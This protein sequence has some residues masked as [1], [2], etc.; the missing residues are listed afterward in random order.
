MATTNPITG[1]LIKTKGYSD[2]FDENFDK[3]D[4]SVRLEVPEIDYD[5]KLA[6]RKQMF[7]DHWG[8][9]GE[10]GE[11]QCQLKLEM[12]AKQ[13]DVPAIWEDIKPYQSQ[14]TGEIIEG[15]VA[16][17][18]HLK[19]HGLVEAADLP[20]EHTQHRN[21]PKDNLKE[22]IARQVYEKLRYR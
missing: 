6:A 15:R 14:A 18:Q 2:A 10:E 4:R 22:Q 17:K 9:E 11:R 19:R 5:E 12:E 7:L 20:L 8:Y 13:R 21:R 1:D 16:H 3:I